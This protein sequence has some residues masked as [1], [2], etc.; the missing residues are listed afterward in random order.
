MAPVT[1][2]A[3]TEEWLGALRRVVEAQKAIFDEHA[4]IEKRTSYEGVGEGGDDTLVID[5]LCEGAVFAE[6][7][8]LHAAG[9]EFTAVAEERG[10]VA[11][12]DGGSAVRVVIDL[13]PPEV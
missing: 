3:T 1:D 9:H 8:R 5:R 10:T 4:G 6:L 12:G 2:S 11:F 7:E 13:L